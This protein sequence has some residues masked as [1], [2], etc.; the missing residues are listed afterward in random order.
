MPSVRCI[1]LKFR[2]A[3]SL[4]LLGQTQQA[5]ILY[6]SITDPLMDLSKRNVP[7][8]ISVVDVE[9]EII[10]LYF[11]EGS[12]SRIPMQRAQR[13]LQMRLDSLPEHWLH[14]ASAKCLVALV[15]IAQADYK[16]AESLLQDAYRVTVDSVGKTDMRTVVV[17]FAL[18]SAFSGQEEYQKAADT[19]QLIMDLIIP[20][21]GENNELVME[22][23]SSIAQSRRCLYKLKRLE[24]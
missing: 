12:M 11:L 16:Q 15:Y 21:Y 24:C 10:R 4:K 19:H 8:G 14:V 18:A 5:R 22:C 23:E 20:L 7:S 9:D 3:A 2:T 13:V 1:Q 17:L 6:E